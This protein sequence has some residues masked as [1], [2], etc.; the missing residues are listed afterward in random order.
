MD[1]PAAGDDPTGENVAGE[2]PDPE[3]ESVTEETTV[4]DDDVKQIC[5]GCCGDILWNS[6]YAL[7]LHFKGGGAFSDIG[8][9]GIAGCICYAAGAAGSIPTGGLSGLAAAGLCSGLTAAV[10][11]AIDVDMIPNS[12]ELSVDFWDQDE[13]N[14]WGWNTSPTIAV[15]LAPDWEVNYD[16]IW[17]I[18]EYDM[19]VHLGF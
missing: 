12:T 15:G 6:H 18:G 14:F 19:N 1:E 9:A 8:V 11:A 4:Y 5:N 13:S 2:V 7:E 17:K 10:D 3:P 16:E